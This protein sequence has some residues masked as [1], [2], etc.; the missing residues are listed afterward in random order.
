[1]NSREVMG[2]KDRSAFETRLFRHLEWSDSR[3]HLRVSLCIFNRIIY[4]K[5]S[6]ECGFDL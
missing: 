5:M 3:N 1:M 2:D 6:P 4:A